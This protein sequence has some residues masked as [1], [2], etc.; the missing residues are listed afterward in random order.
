[1]GFLESGEKLQ[2]ILHVNQKVLLETVVFGLSSFQFLPHLDDAGIDRACHF[3]RVCITRH[4][5]GHLLR[6]EGR[7]RY[8]CCLDL[9]QCLSC[10][11]QVKVRRETG[12]CAGMRA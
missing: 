1:M 4:I 2:N 11:D 9:F 8:L 12:K 10:R 6:G 5:L 7:K 3:D